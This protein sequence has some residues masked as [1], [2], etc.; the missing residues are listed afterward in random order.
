MTMQA[1]LLDAIEQRALRHLDVLALDAGAHVPR[2]VREPD[3][4]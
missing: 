1:L 3:V 4:A 2:S